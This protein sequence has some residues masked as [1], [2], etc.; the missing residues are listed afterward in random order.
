MPRLHQ[1]YKQSPY[2]KIRRFN[3]MKTNNIIMF[4]DHYFAAL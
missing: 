1:D 4:L 3:Y 2:H